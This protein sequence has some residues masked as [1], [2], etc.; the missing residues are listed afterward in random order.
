MGKKEKSVD[1]TLLPT[2]PGSYQMKDADGKILYIGKAI[3]LR[4]RVRSYFRKNASHSGRIAIMVSLVAK[5]DFTVTHNEVEALILENNLIKREKPPFNV[6]MRDDKTYPYLKLTTTEKFPRLQIVRKVLKDGAAYFGPYVS[7][8]SV[9]S[10]KRLLHRVFPLR[11]SKDVLD[12]SPPRRPCLNY[13]MKRCLGPC[14]GKVTENEYGEMVRS[15]VKF[16][17]GKDREVLAELKRKMHLASKKQE[18]E[19]AAICRDQIL[20]IQNINEKQ[21]MDAARPMDEDYIAVLCEGGAGVVRILMVRGGKLIGDQNFSF[22]KSDDPEKLSGAFIQQFYNSAFAV[23]S[24]IF[25][26]VL[27]EDNEVI[28]KWL[29][30][31]RGGRVSITRPLRGRKKKLVDMAMENA[32]LALLNFSAGEEARKEAL[33]E[34]K[35]TLGMETWPTVMEAIDISNI[36]GVSAVGSLVTFFNGQPSNKDYKRYK[37]TATGPDDYAMIS[38][39]VRRRFRRLAHEGGNFPD[40]LLID[41]GVGQISAAHAATSEFAPE[42][43]IIGIAK[44]E[45]RDDPATDKIYLHRRKPPLPFP[46]ASAGKF[47]L[48]RLRDEAHRFAIQYHRKTRERK[49]YASE[50]DDLRGFGPKRKK[51]LLKK[52]GSLKAAKTASVEEIRTT[53]SINEKLAIDILEKL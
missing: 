8:K 48:Q 22:H 37:I 1:L 11:S 3:N 34:I 25:L 49:A 46:A 43:L 15:V 16:L 40:V 17:R 39:V 13:Q 31:L 29:R 12:N 47:M 24:D 33:G 35:Q 9:R 6:M 14:G 36:S 7:A 10:A 18:Y 45:H 30:E 32:K 42:Q 51:A 52:Y 50:V 21:K 41:G 44:G 20:A 5:V 2:R 4:S 27:P 26:N 28:E 23:P 38:E 53:L 19:K